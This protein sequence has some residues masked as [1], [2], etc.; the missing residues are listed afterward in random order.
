MGIYR[1]SNRTVNV[2]QA[3]CLWGQRA[4][5]LLSAK[6]ALSLLVRHGTH[7]PGRTWGNRR[8]QSIAAATRAES[9]LQPND[10]RS[11]VATESR[12]QRCRLRHFANPGA[13]PQAANERAPLAQQISAG[14]RRAA[15]TLVVLACIA[16][17]SISG[18]TKNRS[19]MQLPGYRAVSV[20]Y[21]PMNKMIMSVRI[22]GQPANLLV[23]TGAS[24][25][26]LDRDVAESAGVKPFQRALNQVHFSVPS[27]VFTMG[28]EINGQLLPVG[29]AHLTAGGM[30]F[31]SSPVALSDPSHSGAGAGRVD[32]VLGLDI[33]LRHKALINCRT[34]LVFFKVDQARRINLAFVTSSEKFTRVPVQREENGALTVPCSIRGQPTRLV[35]DTGAF[36]TILHENFATSLGLVAEPTRISAQFARGVSKRIRAA[37]I[38][39]FNIGAFKVPPEKFGVAPLPHFA[40]Q[41]GS[42]KIAGILGMDTLYICHAIIDLDGMNLFLK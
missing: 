5:R 25:V 17:L 18:V 32:G 38:A 19:A 3:S 11:H 29:L 14:T 7:R 1:L 36:V 15:I 39:D 31:G 40:L 6:G 28:S 34:K 27:Q 21:G 41:Q 12:F 42:S 24:Q 33:L 37:K 2:A 9:A 13:L 16:P 35:I 8:R 23:D 4:S 22:N 10:H 26:I 30:N 20:H